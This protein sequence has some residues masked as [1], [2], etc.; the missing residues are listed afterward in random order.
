MNIGNWKLDIGSCTLPFDFAHGPEPVEGEL[1]TWNQISLSLQ[2]A[3]QV[4][5]RL[6]D[7]TL[8]FYGVGSVRGG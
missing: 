2:S 1:G 8:Q 3:S 6:V 7:L 5:S 4:L